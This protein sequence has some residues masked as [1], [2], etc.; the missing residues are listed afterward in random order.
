M[1][2]FWIAEQEEIAKTKAPE[3]P[4]TWEDVA[5]MKYTWKAAME[6]LRMIPPVFGAFRRVLKDIEYGG[7]LIPKGWQ[8]SLFIQMFFQGNNRRWPTFR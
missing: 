4:L 3:D 6:T 2:R 5:K 1:V 8:V 7:Y